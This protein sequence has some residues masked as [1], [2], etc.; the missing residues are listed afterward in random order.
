MNVHIK[1]FGCSANLADSE[2][3]AGLLQ[4]EGYALVPE[5]KN[6]DLIIVNSCSVKGRAETKLF[7]T[8][9][10]IKKPVVVAG[11]VPQ[12]EP[13]LI[14]TKLQGYSVLGTSQL[15]NIARVVQKTLEGNTVVLLGKGTTERLHIPKVRTNPLIEIT[16]ISSGCLSS[17]H[18]LQNK[19]R[20]GKARFLSR[21]SHCTAY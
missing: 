21:G 12:A 4:K 14:K 10:K 19:I 6:A 16:P 11:C 9:R 5:E 8:L 7:K 18:L 20:S 13:S 2:V 3:M 15:D 17:L 1:T